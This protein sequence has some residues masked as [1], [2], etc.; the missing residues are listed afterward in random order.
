MNKKI[1][2]IMIL[3]LSVQLVAASD[4]PFPCWDK[5]GI[6]SNDRILEGDNISI[7]IRHIPPETEPTTITFTLDGPDGHQSNTIDINNNNSYYELY[8]YM[9]ETYDFRDCLTVNY[10]FDNLPN[11]VYTVGGYSTIVSGGTREFVE[12]YGCDLWGCG[13]KMSEQKTNIRLG[14]PAPLSNITITPYITTP[15]NQD[16]TVFATVVGGILNYAQHVFTV[17]GEFIFL[18]YNIDGNTTSEKVIVTN[19][20]KTIPVA[21]APTYSTTAITNDDVVVTITINENI[22]ESSTRTLTHTFNYNGDYTF[23]FTDLAGNEGSKLAR[24]SNINESVSA[25]NKY[26]YPMDIE[27][28]YPTDRT[29]TTNVTGLRFIVDSTNKS[30]K[31]CWYSNGTFTSGKG[32]CEVDNINT[33]DIEELGLFEGYNEWRVWV[34][35]SMGRRRSDSVRFYMD[36]PNT[37][38]PVVPITPITPL[39]VEAPIVEEPEEDGYFDSFWIGIKDNYKQILISVLLFG[40]LLSL[41]GFIVVNRRPGGAKMIYIMENLVLTDTNNGNVRIYPNHIN[42]AYMDVTFLTTP[43]EENLSLDR[44]G[45]VEIIK[46]GKDI[47]KEGRALSFPFKYLF[48]NR[49]EYSH[50]WCYTSRASSL[51]ATLIKK[52]FKKTLIVKCDT[53]LLDQ[54]AKLTRKIWQYLTI[55]FPLKNADFVIAESNGILNELASITDKAHIIP[56]C[57]S[58][59]DLSKL[60]IDNKKENTIISIGRLEPIKGLLDLIDAFFLFKELPGKQD[61]ILKIIGP[62]NNKEYIKTL[63][64]RIIELNI[65]D[66]IFITGPLFNKD[67]YQEMSKAKIYIIASHPNGDGKNNTLPY[68]MYYGCQ[69]IV[70]DVGDLRDTIAPLNIKPIPP[71]DVNTLAKAMKYYSKYPTD[72]YKLKRYIKNNLDWDIYL[73]LFGELFNTEQQED[74]WREETDNEK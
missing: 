56:N 43:N 57:V 20:D 48:K 25:E 58:V 5:N 55:K 39:P 2:I 49:K 32:A 3:L 54:N 31:Q 71:K 4:L 38:T 18:A 17:N 36:F 33:V 19:I 65:Q 51:W 41:L 37:L 46:E 45:K 13:P 7:T 26:D 27:I 62:L 35:D 53:V 67:L 6:Q 28:E 1:L 68:A 66:S 34:E 63:N 30:T 50:I 61:W 11:G 24:V 52:V 72:K 69:P 74:S 40:S 44:I 12:C 10:T 73:P 60:K 23:T 9:H 21:T 59:E 16:I 15:I 64:D 47:Y 14:P 29:Y 42:D 8:S 70:T 22:T